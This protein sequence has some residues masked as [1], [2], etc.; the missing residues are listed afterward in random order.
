MEKERLQ[1]EFEEQ[2]KH[3]RSI[4][5][6]MFGT[7]DWIK[8]H[9][10]ICNFSLFFEVNPNCL[11]EDFIPAEIGLAAFSLQDGVV[12]NFARLIDPSKLC[13]LVFMD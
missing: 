6:N 3:N 11:L 10:I 12:D 9:I 8:K 2:R 13:M 7:D 4:V 1:R 5:W